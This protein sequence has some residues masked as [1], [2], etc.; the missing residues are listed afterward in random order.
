MAET[1]YGARLWGTPSEGLLPTNNY[2]IGSNS[3][4]YTKGD[5]VAHQGGQL[6]IKGATSS[7]GIVG[8]VLKTATMSSTNVT[9]AKVYPLYYDVSLK[10]SVWL[11]GTNEDLTATSSVGYGMT[12]HSDGTTAIQQI[13][14]SGTETIAVTDVEVVCVAVDPQSEG[15]TGSGSGLRQGLF[16]FVKVHGKSYYAFK[17]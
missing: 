1:I 15:G 3:T 2:F 7:P 16:K 4:T 13:D 8:V 12:V 14:S 5:I 9:V 6:V 11:C 10:E 17:N